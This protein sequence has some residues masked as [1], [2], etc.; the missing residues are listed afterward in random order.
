M[1]CECLSMWKCECDYVL[2]MC[3]HVETCYGYVN[4]F[5]LR[6]IWLCANVIF[7]ILMWMDWQSLS[8]WKCVYMNEN[9][10]MCKCNFIECD[11]QIFIM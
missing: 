4:V 2:N 6:K 9:M 11:E 8:M 7:C 10:A 1:D 5:T 3:Y